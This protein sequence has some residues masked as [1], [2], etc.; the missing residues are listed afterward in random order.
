MKDQ[1]STPT[2]ITLF[3]GK[4]SKTLDAGSVICLGKTFENDEARREHC[5][6]SLLV[7]VCSV[8]SFEND[9]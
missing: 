9:E 3:E 4:K 2:Q 7:H 1:G 6:T 8:I 5:Q